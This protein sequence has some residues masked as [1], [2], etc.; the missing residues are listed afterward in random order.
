MYVQP[1][2]L[3]LLTAALGIHKVLQV[4]NM[5]HGATEQKHYWIL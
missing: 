4:K 3:L 2:V 5:F 1:V